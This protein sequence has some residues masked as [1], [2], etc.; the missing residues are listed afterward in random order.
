MQQIIFEYQFQILL[1]FCDL[2]KQLR[3]YVAKKA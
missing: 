1:Y 2:K 3:S